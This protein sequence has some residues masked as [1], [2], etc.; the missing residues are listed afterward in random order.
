MK[1][2]D[3]LFHVKDHKKGTAAVLFQKLQLFNYQFHLWDDNFCHSSKILSEYTY[4]CEPVL[5]DIIKKYCIA[6]SYCIRNNSNLQQEFIIL[7]SNTVEF[8]SSHY[9]IRRFYGNRLSR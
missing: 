9:K 4:D 6:S 3:I 7:S 8:L 5:L 2:R 1:R